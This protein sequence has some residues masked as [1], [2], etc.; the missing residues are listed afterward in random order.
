MSIWWHSAFIIENYL[1]SFQVALRVWGVE[2][3]VGLYLSY[4]IRMSEFIYG[5]KPASLWHAFPK[6][7]CV[8]AIW[9]PIHLNGTC[10]H[11]V[12]CRIAVSKAKNKEPHSLAEKTSVKRRRPTYAVRY[13][14]P[15][16]DV[17]GTDRMYAQYY[18][19]IGN[20]FSA[21]FKSLFY[22]T[23]IFGVDT[24]FKAYFVLSKS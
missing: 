13:Q 20:Y 9:P 5:W 7:G 24:F 19:I 16:W 10:I 11:P 18:K 2:V 14:S 1:L 4:H 8:V 15:R 21:F 3:Y 23:W 6:T 17:Y 22:L 12:P